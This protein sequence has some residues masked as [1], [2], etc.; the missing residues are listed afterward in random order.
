MAVAFW[1]EGAT[2]AL[3]LDDKGEA[4]TVLCNL[5]S[6]GTNPEEIR[7][8]QEH[9]VN[10]FQC[11]TLHSKL[12]LFDDSTLI[13]GSSNASA[14]G[15]ALQGAQLSGWHE[16]NFLIKDQ[17]IYRAASDWFDGLSHRDIQDED[18][19]RARRA[20]ERRR[21]AVPDQLEGHLTLIEFM[22]QNP[23]NFRNKRIFVC[24][25]RED[26][27]DAQKRIIL[28][29]RDDTGNSNIDGFG[30]AVPE[31]A[32]LICFWIGPRWGIA[33]DGY[34]DTTRRPHSR[35]ACGSQVWFAE[36]I[37]DINGISNHGSSAEWAGPLK[38]WDAD[39]DIA[40]AA[41][42]H[43]IFED[44]EKYLINAEEA[45]GTAWAP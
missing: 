4:V 27:T 32:S 8:L 34:W 25:Y 26:L 33:F 30:W 23:E 38:K 21:R 14:N 1:G 11:D 10:V 39:I 18:L 7:R 37:R 44:F 19:Q 3:G 5:V 28:D 24:A 16:A 12:Y 17:E 15:L 40:T 36:R 13:I 42:P 9:S 41:M 43:I 35:N 20:F 2:Q 45:N 6:G 31:D 22:R 29:E